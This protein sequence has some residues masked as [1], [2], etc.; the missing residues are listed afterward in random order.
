MFL[1]LSRASVLKFWTQVRVFF[2]K[3]LRDEKSVVYLQRVRTPMGFYVTTKTRLNV[4]LDCISK[5]QFKRVLNLLEFFDFLVCPLF[6]HPSGKSEQGRKDGEEEIPKNQ[7]GQKATFTQAVRSTAINKE[8]ADIAE[9][10][11]HAQHGEIVGGIGDFM[12][13]GKRRG[14]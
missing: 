10:K 7:A 6:P 12:R 13:E 11:Q 2:E 4:A 14:Q 8:L 5:N 9:Q 3:V 1:I